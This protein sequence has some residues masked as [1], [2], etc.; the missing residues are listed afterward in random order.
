MHSVPATVPENEEPFEPCPTPLAWQQVVEQCAEQ[1]TTFSVSVEGQSI[2]AWSIGE[3]PPLY[4]ING[5]LGTSQLLSLTAWLMKDNFR[6]VLFDLPDGFRSHSRNYSPVVTA[7]ARHCGDS[8]FALY[9]A[10]LGCVTAF[11]QLLN[12][13]ATIVRVVMQGAYSQCPLSL[14]E[15]VA[16]AVGKWVPGAVGSV[17]GGINMLHRSHFP[18]F[19]PYD[20]SRW[21]FA[22]NELAGTKTST[23]CQRV[24]TLTGFDFTSRLASI[25]KPTLLVR[26]E[27]DSPR[28]VA[29]QDTLEQQIPGV[30]VE[31]L[32]TCGRLPFLTHPHRLKKILNAFLI[33]AG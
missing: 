28:Q 6:C 23:L 19:P 24:R 10:G 7:I 8:Q 17:P 4:F 13:S 26:C 27:G 14:T 16:S 21:V 31:W 12:N 22:A 33:D 11:D 3:G 20:Q 2:S 25:Q 1:R 29:A 32:H 18:W 5:V 30:A 15:R 9:A